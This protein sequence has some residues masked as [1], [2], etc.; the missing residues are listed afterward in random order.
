VSVFKKLK[1]HLNF[2]LLVIFSSSRFLSRI[3]FVFSPRFEE[4]NFRVL[5][6]RLK[7]LINIKSKNSNSLLRRNIHRLEKGMYM[8]NRRKKF[9]TSYIKETVEMFLNY[10]HFDVKSDQEYLWS[11]HV[12]SN[13]FDICELNHD[14]LMTKNKFVSV[15]KEKHTLNATKDY[16]SK[17]KLSL[18]PLP[19][20]SEFQNLCHSRASVRWFTDQ[21]PPIEY[22]RKALNTASTSPS[23]CNRQP[24]RFII[25]R[26]S[27]FTKSILDCTG[28][29]A[30]FAHQVPALVVVI[31]N[32]DYFELEKDRHLIYID[33]SLAA[34][35]FMLSCK[36][37]GLSTCT[38]NWPDVGRE[39]KKISKVIDLKSSE[40]VIMLIGVGFA[41]DKIQIPTSQKKQNN[42]LFTEIQ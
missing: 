7:Y 15:I 42:D 18:S 40:R 39:D 29:T 5:K 37:L 14:L 27:K 25:S 24:Y 36:T 11:S 30:G 32:L 28:G 38:F 34:M 31:G 9:A 21:Q 8:K 22:I 10:D 35:Q 12:L 1:K 26:S 23:A 6:G 41:D 3:Y 20:F 19:T 17:S 16:I 4:E 33:S 2:Y 13:Y